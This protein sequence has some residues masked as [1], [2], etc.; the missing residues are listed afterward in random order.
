MFDIIYPDS[1]KATFTNREKE[2]ALLEYARDELLEGTPQKISLFGL[3]RIGKSILIKEFI[4]RH[5]YED[6]FVPI[7]INFENIVTDPENFATKY[8]GWTVYWALTR[9]KV[10]V[11]DYLEP[12]SLVASISEHKELSQEIIRLNRLLSEAKVNRNDL[13]NLAF[14]MPEKL[15][16][17]F[18][19]K[20]MVFLDE[21]QDLRLLAS[22]NGSH[23]VLGVFRTYC[24]TSSTSYVILGSL[25]SSMR[26]LVENAQS[27]IFGQFDQHEL[28]YFTKEDSIK[29]FR[30]ILPRDDTEVTNQVYQYSGGHPFY[31]VQLA[32]RMKLLHV[33][34]NLEITKELVGQAF[35]IETLSSK[36]GIYNH[37]NYLY[38]ISLEKASH[39][40]S[41]KSVLRILAKQEG[42]NQSQVARKL[43]IAQ[44]AVRNY[45][46][47]LLEVDII[48]RKE[49][50]YYFKDS[51]LR[52]WIA[53][54]EQEIELDEF[55]R[56]EDILSLVHRLEEKFS[57]V[58]SELGKSKEYE[59]LNLVKEMRGQKFPGH[60]FGV[61]ESIEFPIFSTIKNYLWDEGR[62]EIDFL[63]V[64]DETW[65]IE[66]KWKISPAKYP[67]VK[68]FFERSESLN[69][70][71]RWFISK[72]G[73]TENAKQLALQKH[74]FM[75][76]PEDINEIK[77]L[78]SKMNS[79]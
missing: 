2:L 12:A 18:G 45:L 63:C 29:L 5:L 1:L 19:I 46:N 70:K 30:R 48:I 36:G 23:N 3:R 52:Y 35:V 42:L 68:K 33:L 25:I 24:E 38:N 28:S 11:E 41:L 9:G 49:D 10:P 51:V 37:C 40:V 39:Y 21:F 55:P 62:E 61:Q 22:Y 15:A 7:Y 59:I 73:F 4:S 79:N 75:S 13:L 26:Y 58:S 27:P 47:S 72:S 74:I 64:N 20:I 53:A 16:R 14:S 32:K 66:L 57:R 34:N 71:K 65:S 50:K 6:N 43:R 60:L 44:G 17:L 67:Q 78:L 77:K 54:T 56:Q 31:I 76:E 69:A 8:I